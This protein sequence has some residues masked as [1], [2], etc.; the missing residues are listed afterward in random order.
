MRY[1]WHFWQSI[2]KQSVVWFN[3]RNYLAIR[4]WNIHCLN[5]DWTQ[6]SDYIYDHEKFILP[7]QF[8]PDQ[9]AHYHEARPLRTLLPAG[10]PVVV[11]RRRRFDKWNTFY[12]WLDVCI[13][14]WRLAQSKMQGRCQLV[15]ILVRRTFHLI[16]DE[17][18]LLDPAFNYLHWL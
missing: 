12:N 6:M 15:K 14:L 16:L 4:I 7:F 13:L 17:S 11:V 1:S 2:S 5:D 3:V 9:D 18:K 8:Q 10:S